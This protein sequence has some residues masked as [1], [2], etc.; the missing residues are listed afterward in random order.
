MSPYWQEKIARNRRRDVNNF[1]KLRRSGWLVIR[2]WQ[3][4][5]EKDAEACVDRI[6]KA[7]RGTT[8][9]RFR[10]E[11]RNYDTL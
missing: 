4:E 1:R 9:Q 11:S 6:E 5:V 10:S 7:V 3:H 8:S 2:I